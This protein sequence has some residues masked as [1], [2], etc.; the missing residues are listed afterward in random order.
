MPHDEESSYDDSWACFMKERRARMEHERYECRCGKRQPRATQPDSISA[1][2]MKR[3]NEAAIFASGAIRKPRVRT[4]REFPVWDS[5]H[6][7]SST[8][9][10]SIYGLLSTGC[11]PQLDVIHRMRSTGCYEWSPL[12]ANQP[13]CITCQ[14]AKIHRARFLHAVQG[15]KHRQRGSRWPQ[16]QRIFLTHHHPRR[17]A[18]W[19]NSHVM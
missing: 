7:M 3:A 11:D 1:R 2:D 10:N 12:I 17:A 19:A 6:R 15:C 13:R 8:G 5:I 18:T 14:S 9:S 16:A 4:P